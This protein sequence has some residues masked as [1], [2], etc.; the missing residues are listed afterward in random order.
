MLEK[1]VQMAYFFVEFNVIYEL[2]SLF[3]WLHVYIYYISIYNIS[4]LII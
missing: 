2:A 1:G 4:I 3:L